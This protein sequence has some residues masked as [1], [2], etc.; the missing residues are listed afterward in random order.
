MFISMQLLVYIA[1]FQTAKS[2]NEII[3]GWYGVLKDF[4]VPLVA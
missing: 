4:K 1:G 3:F 2:Y